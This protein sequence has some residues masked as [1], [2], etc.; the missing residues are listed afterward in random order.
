[1]C[2]YWIVSSRLLIHQCSKLLLTELMTAE[3]QLTRS[4][5]KIKVTVPGC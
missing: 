1:M 4:S 2:S 5:Q 3:E